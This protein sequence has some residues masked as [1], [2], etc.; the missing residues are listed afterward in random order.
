MIV[1]REFSEGLGEPDS[2]RLRFFD[3]SES[4]GGTLETSDSALGLIH[5]SLDGVAHVRD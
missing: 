3:L 1:L 5:M 4:F 2:D